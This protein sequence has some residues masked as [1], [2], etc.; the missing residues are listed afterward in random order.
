[1]GFYKPMR[2]LPSSAFVAFRG[3]R[4]SGHLYHL[5]RLYG[6]DVLIL[7]A[8]RIKLRY[9]LGC[10]DIDDCIDRLISGREITRL[11]MRYGYIDT[12][13]VTTKRS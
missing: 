11:A 6:Y 8:L 5:A 12:D 9:P 4:G 7:Q 1:M 3:A 2:L 13:S 10:P